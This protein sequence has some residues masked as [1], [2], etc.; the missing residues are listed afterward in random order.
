MG[1]LLIG[2]ILFATLHSSGDWL[3]R[4]NDGLLLG[5]AL[6]LT[7]SLW[8]TISMHAFSNLL[9]VVASQTS[10]LNDYMAALAKTQ[11]AWLQ[12]SAVIVN[13]T[14]A[15]SALVTA[16]ACGRESRVNT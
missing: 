2:V 8:L 5:T 3:P 1:A 15:M 9:I 13:A 6:L 11:P 16:I 14:V 7:R 12:P 4:I 10:W